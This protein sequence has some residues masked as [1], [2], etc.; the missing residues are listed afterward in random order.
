MELYLEFLPKGM[1]MNIITINLLISDQGSSHSDSCSGP[2][3][4]MSCLGSHGHIE[5]GNDCNRG[6]VF[7][8]S[9]TK[10]SGGRAGNGIILICELKL[11]RSN[12]SHLYT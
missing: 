11:I 3:T 7:N 6:N 9:D 10:M 4:S 2:S 8:V 1:T 5:P 12:N